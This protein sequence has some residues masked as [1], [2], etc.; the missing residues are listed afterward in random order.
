MPHPRLRSLGRLRA[1]DRRRPHGLALTLAAMLLLAAGSAP[2]ADQD[3]P[4]PVSTPDDRPDPSD[5]PAIRSAPQRSPVELFAAVERAWIAG[6]AGALA[7][8]C[9]STEAHVSLKPGGSPASAPTLGGLAFLIDDPLHLVAT[10]SFSVVRIAVDS[11]KPLARAWAR[12][13]GDWGGAKGTREL[14][15]EL[16]ARGRADGRW[17]LTEI[18]AND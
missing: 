8:Y 15:V 14:Q 13:S 2:A 7:S 18:R 4:P 5:R 9:D 6:D 10:S 1:G 11:K 12:W 16:A 3:V 17:L